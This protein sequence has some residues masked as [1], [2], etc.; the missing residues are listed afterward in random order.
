MAATIEPGVRALDS[1][2]LFD[3]NVLKPRKKTRSLIVVLIL[4]SILPGAGH[5]SLGRKPQ[6]LWLL[7]AFFFGQIAAAAAHF[8]GVGALSWLSMR[9]LVLIY[10]YG[11]VDAALLQVE[12]GD[13]RGDRSDV[14]PRNAAFGNLVLYGLGYW[15][16]DQ[17][18][19]AWV[20]IAFGTLLH[21]LVG[22]THIFLRILTEIGVAGLALHGYKMAADE[23]LPRDTKSLDFEPR[24]RRADSTPS[25]LIPALGVFCVVQ[26]ALFGFVHY[27]GSGINSAMEVNQ[28]QSLRVE[29]YYRNSD[30]GVQLELNAPGWS[31]TTAPDDEFVR[32][33]HMSEHSAMR[34]ILRPRL[35]GFPD[36]QSYAQILMGEAMMSGSMLE[37]RVSGPA[38]IAGLDGW[39]IS[40]ISHGAGETRRF[41]LRTAG[42]GWYQFF[43]WFEWD[44][45]NDDF[46]ESELAHVM[47]SLHLANS[48]EF[49]VE[50]STAR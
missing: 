2:K 6:G 37:E 43:L 4:A 7:G 45:R 12:I 14:R 8:L 44:E 1:V 18:A 15:Q 27:V 28:R 3:D 33:R 24:R 22:E 13:R 42:R 46:G 26:L 20:A 29:P 50:G 48:S 47:S 19:W 39:R 25:W 23:A 30:Y 9:A 10:L 17:K 5:L 11:V 31:F 40:G 34:L 49:P 21:G 38:T 32:A 35:W 36:S 16:L 41:E